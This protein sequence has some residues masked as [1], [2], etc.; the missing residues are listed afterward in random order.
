[1]SLS[2]CTNASIHVPVSMPAYATACTVCMQ[3]CVTMDQACM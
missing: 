2:V 1:M 3:V